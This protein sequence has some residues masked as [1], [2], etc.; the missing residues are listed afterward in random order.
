MDGVLDESCGGL[1][2]MPNSDPG[3]GKGTWLERLR[4]YRSRPASE[5]LFQQTV[6]IQASICRALEISSRA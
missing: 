3:I 6:M 4:S 1:G 2:K 5:R